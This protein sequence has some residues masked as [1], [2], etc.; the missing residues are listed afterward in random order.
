MTLSGSSANLVAKA[1]R[2]D[3]SDLIAYSLVGLEVERQLRIVALNDDL[4]GLLDSLCTNATHFGGVCCRL[5]GRS[6]GV[7]VGV[8]GKSE[9]FVEMFEC[10]RKEVFFRMSRKELLYWSGQNLCG[11]K[12]VK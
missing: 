10:C 5:V 4:G 12:S 6:V 11:E 3:N 2:G 8:G 9:I 7:G 1:L